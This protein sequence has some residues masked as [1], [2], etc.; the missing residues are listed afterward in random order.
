MFETTRIIDDDV[1][2]IVITLVNW[3]TV[4][5]ELLNEIGNKQILI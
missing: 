1:M 4:H 3:Y 5:T 2:K